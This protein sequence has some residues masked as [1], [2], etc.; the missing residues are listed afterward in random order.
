MSAW[1]ITVN[2]PAEKVYRAIFNYLRAGFIKGSVITNFSEPSYIGVKHLGSSLFIIK[3]RVV[4][5]GFKSRVLLDFD[6]STYTLIWLLAIFFGFITLFLTRDPWTIWWI[7]FGI[8]ILWVDTKR[9]SDLYKDKISDFLRT[10]ERTGVLPEF[11]VKVKE[12]PPVDVK[13]LYERLV[14]TYSSVYGRGARMVEREIQSYMG[15]GLSREE[16]IR[17]LA[18]SEGLLEVAEEKPKPKPEVEEK[19]KPR[20]PPD[21]LYKRLLDVYISVYGRGEPLLERKI[22]KYVS[23]GL[24]REEAITRLAEEEGLTGRLEVAEEPSPAGDLYSRL[25]SLYIRRSREAL[26]RKIEEYMK[27]GLS[28]EEAIKR[29]AEEEGIA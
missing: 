9:I 19:P 8:T 26:E 27:E 22:E 6:F 15:M 11:E 13:A 29:L 7:T 23:K 2:L 21:T 24:S 17:R 14:R 1:G 12:R 4:P 20:L 3:I 25:A 18:E 16:A 10:V 5:Q 28:R